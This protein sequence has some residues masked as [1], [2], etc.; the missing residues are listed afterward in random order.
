MKTFKLCYDVLMT[1]DVEVDY[2]YKDGFFHTRLS[3]LKP[4]IAGFEDKLSF[5]VSFAFAH[6]MTTNPIMAD[7]INNWSKLFKRFKESDNFECISK[8][9]DSFQK[10]KGLKLLKPYSKKTTIGP[11]TI[12]HEFDSLIKAR[13]AQDFHSL[14]FDLFGCDMT[15][16]LIWDDTE[17][18]V[19]E[20]SK[21]NSDKF[22]K[23][24]PLTKEESLWD[25]L[26]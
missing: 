22:R 1:T 13:P 5:L 18:L 2:T 12:M 25:Y 19:R 15:D 6:F 21:I 9:L 11:M 16:F 8:A 4:V 17:V 3:T 24:H 7:E 20:E 10:S 26:M 23:K 14:F